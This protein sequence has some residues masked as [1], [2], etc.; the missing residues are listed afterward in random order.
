[1]GYSEYSNGLARFMA[2][3]I[4][5]STPHNG[6]TEFMAH[7]ENIKISKTKKD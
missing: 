2:H 1:M 4:I 6:Q 7:M 3:G 5:I